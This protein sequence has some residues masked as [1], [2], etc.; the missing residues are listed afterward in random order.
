M[1]DCRKVAGLPGLVLTIKEFPPKG[2]LLFRACLV[3]YW[4]YA[5]QSQVTSCMIRVNG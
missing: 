2:L 1:L 5:P 4:S 3:Q